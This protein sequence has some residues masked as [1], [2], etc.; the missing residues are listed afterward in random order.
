MRKTRQKFLENFPGIGKRLF[1]WGIYL[2]L[3]YFSGTINLQA[4]TDSAVKVNPVSY[5]HL[6]QPEKKK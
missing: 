3:V 4:Q 1:K 6:K 5:T 2:L